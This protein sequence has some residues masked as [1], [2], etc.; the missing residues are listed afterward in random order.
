MSFTQ[1]VVVVPTLE[2]VLKFTLAM[3]KHSCAVEYY[4]A[5]LGIKAQEIERPHDIAG[6]NNKF[7]PEIMKRLALEYHTPAVNCSDYI[8]SALRLHRQQYHHQIWN[9]TIKADAPEADLQ[10]SAIDAICSQRED[11]KHHGGGH[12]F[13]QIAVIIED[14]P[15]NKVKIMREMLQR[16][17]EVVEPRVD[18]I[19]SL[20]DFPNVG[21]PEEKYYAARE[22]AGNTARYIKSNYS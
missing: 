13:E 18:L 16:M 9:G 17:R 20:D 7:E 2:E 5:Q 4:S 11:R 12:T 1:P 22:I 3:L 21:I 15:Q 6:K 10:L 19:T 14:N 8:P